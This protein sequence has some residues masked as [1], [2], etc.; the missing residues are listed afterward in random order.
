MDQRKIARM[1]LFV[2]NV[3]NFEANLSRVSACECIAL[4]DM[5]MILAIPNS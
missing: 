5:D 3:A 4:G 1:F 2:A